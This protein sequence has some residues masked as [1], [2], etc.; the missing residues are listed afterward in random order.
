MRISIIIPVYNSEAFLGSCL[1]SIYHQT[2]PDFDC[3]LVDDGSTDKSGEICDEWCELDSRFRVIHQTNK[4]VSQARNAAL[5]QCDTQW[6]TFVDSDDWLNEDYLALMVEETSKHPN[7]DIIISSCLTHYGDNISEYCVMHNSGCHKFGCQSQD[8]INELLVKYKI[9]APWGKLYKK[10]IIDRYN[11]LFPADISYGEDL[12]FNIAYFSCIEYFAIAQTAIYNY[13]VR[14]GSLSKKVKD[15]W[16]TNY[17]QWVKL[18]DLLRAKNI[19]SPIINETIFKRLWYSIEESI[20]KSRHLG[21]SFKDE[22]K[23]IKSILSIPEIDDRRFKTCDCNCS[24][25]IKYIIMN[26]QSLAFALINHFLIL[27]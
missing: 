7:V 16:K 22:Y 15:T 23:Y 4:G 19:E 2:Y 21:L 10:S 1:S 14:D 27:K 6:V 3:I 13:I 26:R 9:M 25:W 12:I 5:A 8:V 18:F 20:F 11:I 24:A 17:P